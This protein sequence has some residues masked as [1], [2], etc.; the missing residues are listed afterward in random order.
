MLHSDYL[1][2][3]PRCPQYLAINPPFLSISPTYIKIKKV[4]LRAE[5]QNYNL[6]NKRK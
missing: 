1:T 6:N 2:L 3:S 5:T 4:I